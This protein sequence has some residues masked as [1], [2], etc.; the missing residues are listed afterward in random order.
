M[1]LIKDPAFDF[2]CSFP[3]I[4]AFNRIDDVAVQEGG[5]TNGVDER[6]QCLLHGVIQAQVEIIQGRANSFHFLVQILQSLLL[7]TPLPQLNWATVWVELGT[8][9]HGVFTVVPRRV[10]FFA[11]TFVLTNKF[12]SFPKFAHGNTSSTPILHKTKA[13]QPCP[14]FFFRP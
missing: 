9:S 3:Q 14:R 7:G 5:P 10:C 13:N 1:V 8:V 4:I 12:Y 11:E 6:D 2:L